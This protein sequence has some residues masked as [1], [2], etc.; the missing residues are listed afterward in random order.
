MELRGVVAVC[1]SGEWFWQI[2]STSLKLQTALKKATFHLLAIRG[3]NNTM[4]NTNEKYKKNTIE[5]LDN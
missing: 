4:T 2:C 5:E 3:N 1:I